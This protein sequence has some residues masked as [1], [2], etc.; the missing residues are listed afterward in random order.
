MSSFFQKEFT[1]D[2]VARIF[3][4]SVCVF[5]SAW[6]C[7]K[8]RDAII[9][10]IIG[11]IL[12]SALMP[13]VRFF[14]YRLHFKVRLIAILATLILLIGILTALFLLFVPPTIAEFKKT[15][16]LVFKFENK[17][18]DDSYIPPQ[19]KDYISKF[20]DFQEYKEKFN[21]REAFDYVKRHIPQLLDIM[22]KAVF[23]IFNLIIVVFFFLYCF[24]IL[25]YYDRL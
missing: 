13:I 11:W 7:Y 3:F 1:F 17:I 14:Q 9:P 23:K 5:I 15:G 12:A 22:S 2:R 16:D 19:V 20:V 25:L 4:I 24:F 6:I 10:F 18:M 8:I 21:S